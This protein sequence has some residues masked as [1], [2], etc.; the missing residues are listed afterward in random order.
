MN[1]RSWLISL[2]I[3]CN[4]AVFI[5]W[6]SDS[7]VMERFLVD[8]FLVSWNGLLEGRYWVLITSVF[9]HSMFLHIFFNMYVLWGFGP[10]VEHVLGVKRFFVFY[11]VAGIFSSLCHAAVS[12]FI[13][14]EPDQ[15]A[16][17][18]SG[19]IA[20]VILLFSLLFPR[21]KILLMGIV[22]LPAVVGALAFIALDI[23]GLVAQAEGGGLPIGH[24][25]HLGG[26]FIGILYFVY[27][28]TRGQRISQF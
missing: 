4:I 3:A 9:S 22:P 15:M 6:N 19:A 14:H 16:L 5:A 26:A 1:Q 13:M 2:I 7:P 25:A 8:N 12:N 21:Q 20:G 24:G 17:G 10:V 23:W 28:R 27:L 11:F 18:A